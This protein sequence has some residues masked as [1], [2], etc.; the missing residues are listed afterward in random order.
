MH[1]IRPREY[2]HSIAKLKTLAERRKAL[3]DVPIEYQSMVKTHLRM[4]FIYRNA[5]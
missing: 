4:I 5:R 2:A 1:P 3:A